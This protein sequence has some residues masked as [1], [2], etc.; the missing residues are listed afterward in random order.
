MKFPFNYVTLMKYDNKIYFLS[1]ILDE[2]EKQGGNR[3]LAEIMYEY[4]LDELRK[5]AY[6]TDE[7][8]FKLGTFGILHY[9]LSGIN[10]VEKRLNIVL[11]RGTN[12][13]NEKSINKR[14]ATLDSKRSKIMKLTERADKFGVKKNFFK[15]IRFNP[16][17]IKN[18]P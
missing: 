7:V 10:D 9:T 3:E 12:P 18:E 4:N 5:Y 1:D 13:P 17:T 8:A 14:L 6:E 11:E 16:I 15:C 2:F